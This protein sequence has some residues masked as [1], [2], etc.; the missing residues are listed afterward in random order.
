MVPTKTKKKH[1]AIF[2]CSIWFFPLLWANLF[3]RLCNLSVLEAQGV[4]ASS[5]C[6]F[7]RVR[8]LCKLPAS[9]STQ[10]HTQHLTVTCHSSVPSLNTTLA[11]HPGHPAAFFDLKG[12]FGFGFLPPKKSRWPSRIR[13]NYQFLTRPKYRFCQQKKTTAR[14]IIFVLF[15]FE[16]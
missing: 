5:A 13:G 8:S 16:L 10:L 4:R 14:T 2:V 15:L 6:S 12:L 1:I 3:S 7:C 9:S 11:P